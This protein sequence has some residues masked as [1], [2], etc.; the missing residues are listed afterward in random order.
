MKI[1]RKEPRA[2]P[3]A[4]FLIPKEA[5]DSYAEYVARQGEFPFA[6]LQA[7]S[8]AGIL[9]E[10]EAS[11]LRGRGGAGFSTGTKW[12]TLACHPCPIRYVVCNAAEGEPGTFKDRYLLRHNPYATLEGIAIACRVIRA[13]EAY[14][15][16]KSSFAKEISILQRAIGETQ[17]AGIF[18]DVPVHLVQGPEEYLFG[19]EKALLS[20]IEGEGPFPRPVE[21]PPYEIG[22][23]ST[24][25]SP[26]PALV[27]NVQTFAHVA[28]IVRFG[29]DSFR[30]L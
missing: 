14:I 13:K 16:I 28:S 29:A 5:E 1:L 4:H 20:V 17:A 12:R 6:K 18:E 27:N 19:E 7:G 22:L 9:C 15:A 2:P 23:F 21:E 24:P 30:K 10:H 25:L 3:D 26:N 11:G 8:K